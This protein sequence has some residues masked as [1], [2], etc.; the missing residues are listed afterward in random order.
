MIAR[1][2]GC[3]LDPPKIAGQRPDWLF[4]LPHVSRMPSSA[5]LDDLILDVRDQGGLGSC[6]AVSFV[7]A[8]RMVR[9]AE[10]ETGTTIG[11]AEFAYWLARK[12]DRSEDEDAGTTFRS[13]LDAVRKL[14]LPP[15]SAWPYDD[16]DTGS[17]NDPFRKQPSTDAF[18]QAY[19]RRIEYRR[20]AQIDP[21][22]RLDAIR[23]AIAGRRPVL[24]GAEVSTDFE[25]NRFDPRKPL[26]PPK[27][28][29]GRHAQIAKGYR[30][31]GSFEILNSW[32]ADWGAN[33][34]SLWSAKYMATASDVWVLSRAGSFS[35]S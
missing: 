3:L 6:V 27:V 29:A 5:N 16:R 14:G 11:S 7:G 21:S 15:E 18:R 31:D 24:F 28:S 32:G 9:V 33:G 8:E 19:D 23:E 34:C 10:G 2:Y 13:L 12:I 22:A 35:I 4:A 26:D 25:Y 20:I 30:A 17:P 1:R